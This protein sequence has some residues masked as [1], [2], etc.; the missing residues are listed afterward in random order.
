METKH[1][2]KSNIFRNKIDCLLVFVFMDA[3]I[4]YFIIMFDYIVIDRCNKN[5][6]VFLEKNP[7]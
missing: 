4:I 2:R 5:I 1:A 7:G 3:W 6:I